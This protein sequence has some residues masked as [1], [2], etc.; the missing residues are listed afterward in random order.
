[1]D[2]TT[3]ISELHTKMDAS[4]KVLDH[5]MK[6]LRT[7]RAS[8]NLLDPVMVDAYGAK[9]PLNQ[10]ATVTCSD[11]RTITVQVWDK[12][13]VKAV[14]KGIVDAGL[15]LNPASDGQLVRLPIPPLTEERR[16]EL[17]KLSHKYGENTKIAVRNVRRD[18]MDQLKKLEKEG[19]ISED[20]MHNFGDDVQKLTDEYV[21]K[22]DAQVKTKEEDIMT[23]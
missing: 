11:S 15:G 20:E 16:K 3:L 22:I 6:G 23:V 9:M 2:S 7:G 18:G 17:V 13:M 1:M 8:I 12:D 19:A 5:E 4:M 10:V 14:E 21:A